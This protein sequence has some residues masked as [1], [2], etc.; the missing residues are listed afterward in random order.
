MD[1]EQALQLLRSRLRALDPSASAGR[2]SAEI[3]AW[4]QTT[5]VVLHEVFGSTHGAVRNFNNINWNLRGTDIV[6]GYDPQ[7]AIAEIKDRHFVEAC[8]RYRGVMTSAI[9]V[10]ELFGPPALGSAAAIA[11]VDVELWTNVGSLVRDEDWPKVASQTAIFVESRLREWAGLGPGAYGKELMLQVFRAGTGIFRLGR[12][13]AEEQGWQ[14]LALGLIGA[15]GNVDRHNI[16][17]R[18]DARLY[19]LGVLGLGSLLLTQVRYQHGNSF[20]TSTG[21]LPSPPETA[22]A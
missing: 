7:R 6:T 1:Q 10:V 18:E 9:E 2:E 22:D 8:A 19:A 16:Q 20:R 3:I 12:T 13:D 5:S 11:D 14:N 15:I 17:Q 4:V 21:A